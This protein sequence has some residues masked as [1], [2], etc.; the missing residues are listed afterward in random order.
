MAGD[1]D[2]T[3]RFLEAIGVGD[4]TEVFRLAAES[5][6]REW[7]R[8]TLSFGAQLGLGLEEQAPILFSALD[9]IRAVARARAPTAS[10]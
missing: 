4:A 9:T 5:D 10:A 6:A 8:R 3:L 1:Q 2:Q 7:M